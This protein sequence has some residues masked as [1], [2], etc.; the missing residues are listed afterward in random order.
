MSMRSPPGSPLL[1]AA[2]LAFACSN[3]EDQAPVTYLDAAN[4]PSGD[5]AVILGGDMNASEPF[6]DAGPTPDAAV[7]T[8]PDTGNVPP[9]DAAEPP[10]PD[11]AVPPPDAAVAPPPDAE[12]TPP[13]ADAAVVLPPD[14]AEPPPPPV[15]CAPAADPAPAQAQEVSPDGRFVRLPRFGGRFIAA[16]RVTVRLPPEGPRPDER[17]PVLY[18]HDGQN[19]F[20]DEEASFGVSWGAIATLDDLAADPRVDAGRAL[21]V[22]VDNSPD[23]VD[24]YT[25]VVDPDYMGGGNA[26]AYGRFLIEELKPYIDF[27]FPTR[28]APEDTG[29][30]GSS[31]GGLV[32]L[33]LGAQHP[34]V[35]GRIAAFSPSL[36]WANGVAFDWVAP[37]AAAVADAP[38]RRLYLD[39]GNFEGSPA[40][41]P[42]SAGRS[43]VVDDGRHF[44]DAIVAALPEAAQNRV[45]LV[46]DPGAAH[47]E[48]AWRRRLPNALRFLLGPPLGEPTADALWPWAPVM[49][50]GQSTRASIFAHDALRD[51]FSL[52]GSA[53]VVATSAPAI[54]SLRAD[55]QLTAVAPGTSALTAPAAPGL[56]VDLTVA[57]ANESIVHL[58][59]NVPEGSGPVYA[60]GSLDR[61]GPWE[62]T[63]LPLRPLTPTLY[64][65]FLAAPTGEPF[66]FKF[67]QGNWDAVEKAPNGAEIANRRYTPAGDA[68]LEVTVQ[69]WGVAP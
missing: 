16:R 23:R 4:G 49:R 59:V 34:E 30:L 19:V 68:E 36:W 66:E 40:E 28:C 18:V 11:A 35:F 13:P 22:A 46:E 60:G 56:A 5:A 67:T 65:G 25:P 50:A 58:L 3:A 9:P 24:D 51:T 37:L 41:G 61:L 69:R 27:H 39:T 14:A 29:L 1:F 2:C 38:G 21:V 63:A 54:V 12:I 47:N 64:E 44:V 62:A 15:A 45:M 6:P 53:E 17:L 8:T 43:S 26:D 57:A 55:G 10:T 7:S 31:L 32:S 33:Y 20:F 42:G 52:L 48:A